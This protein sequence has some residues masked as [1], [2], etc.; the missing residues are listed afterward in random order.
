[1]A[2]AVGEV[3]VSIIHCLMGADELI[4]LLLVELILYA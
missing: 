3:D 2:T 4:Q 1:M